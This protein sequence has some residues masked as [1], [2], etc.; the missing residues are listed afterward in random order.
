MVSRGSV[1]I[2]A[3][4]EQ[5]TY[6]IEPKIASSVISFLNDVLYIVDSI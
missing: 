5:I 6:I 4:A 2:K 1:N 3:K